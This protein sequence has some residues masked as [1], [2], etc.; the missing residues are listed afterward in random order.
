MEAPDR[1]IY[2]Y[3]A[4]HP[5]GAFL[6]ELYQ[7]LGGKLGE[8]PGHVHTELSFAFLGSPGA[9][10]LARHLVGGSICS[11]CHLSPLLIWFFP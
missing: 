4:R 3:L 10:R 11:P 5:A 6:R 9:G 2:D 8:S 7:S 1:L